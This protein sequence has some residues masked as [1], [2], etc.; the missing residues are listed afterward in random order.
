[1]STIRGVNLGGW[2]VLEQ[3]MRPALFDGVSG[4]DETVFCKEKPDAFK[5]LTDH[6]NHFITEADI[7]A[8]KQQGV[9]SVRVPVPW[10]I[11]GEAPYFS[12]LPHLDRLMHWCEQHQLP[13]LLDLHTTPGC[14]NGFDNG[15][16]TG[17]IEWHHDPRHLLL[18][19]EKLVF[20]VR[21]YHHLSMFWGIEVVN[22]PHWTIP[23]DILQSYYQQSYAAIRAESDCAIIFHDGFRPE[24]AAWKTW[25]EHQEMVNV[26]FDLHLYLCFDPKITHLDLQGLA[27]VAWTQRI[28]LIRSIQQFVP[29]II[30]EWSLGMIPE[31]TLKGKDHFQQDL[32]LRTAFAVQMQAFE[33]AYGWYF[34]SYTIWRDTHVGWDFKRLTA[35]GIIPAHFE[36]PL[37]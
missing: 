15:G 1:M 10:W 35:M 11:Q 7:I 30:G 28:E 3:W 12:A 22:E 26:Y 37:E 18:S 36:Q 29:V 19:I 16:V 32:A 23:L 4:P 8:L 21:R 20:Y 24:D 34:W 17:Q 9:N 6:W 31:K 25:F 27:Q 33:E 13:V 5:V 14:Q 2:F